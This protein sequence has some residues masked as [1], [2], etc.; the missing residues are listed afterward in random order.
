MTI[1]K[2][3]SR[4]QYSG[5]DVTVAFSFPYRFFEDSDLEVYILD[6]NDVETLQ[7]ITTH[8][9]VSNN[10]DETG[11]TVTMVTAP[12][13]GE[14]LTI[15]RAIPQTQ[16]TDYQANDPFPAETHEAALDRLTL[17][18]QQQSEEIGRSL[19]APV[20]DTA[21][22]ELPLDRASSFL[23]FDASKNPTSASG[24]SDVAISTAMTPVVQASTLAAA[25]TAMGVIAELSE[26][27]TPQLGG[28]LD[29]N[30]KAVFW[31]KG[32]DVA[33]ASELLVL[34][35][36]NSFDVT[37][38]TSI[39]SIETTADAFGI[40]SLIML[41]F[42]GA[43][44]LTHH[45]TDLVLPGSANITTAA[46][47][48]GIFQKYAAG[49]WRC[50]S[51]QRAGFQ[52]YSL[53]DEDD[54]S[55]DSD[56]QPASQQ[57]ITAYF[58]AKSLGYGQTWQ[59]VAASRAEDTNYQNTTGQPIQVSIWGQNTSGNVTFSFEASTDGVSWV[60]IRGGTTGSADNAS[61]SF[62]AVIPNNHYYRLNTTFGT[63]T[64][65]EWAELRT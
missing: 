50:V 38:T 39:T 6:A 18:T 53:L 48:V 25:R 11:G 9:T 37:G 43:L 59:D 23:F 62:N 34:T 16:G 41:Q 27:T 2:T 61:V 32:A 10:G 30:S 3:T 17:L 65:L 47:D 56:T 7:T 55:S 19:I 52:P 8:Y 31:S 46:G 26:D 21:S 22:L 58:A 14:T 33:S 63:F 40:G 54:M 28:A 42:D 24:V 36:G 13:T 64:K 12:A 29:T 51:Y 4:A 44:T 57:S 49:D 60:V 15:L 20:S 45:A 35:D 1:A 5:N